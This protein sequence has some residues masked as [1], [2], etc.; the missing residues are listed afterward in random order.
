MDPNGFEYDRAVGTGFD[1]DFNDG[2]IPYTS[3]VGT[4]V[5]S[6]YQSYGLNDMVGNVN[7]WCWD[8]YGTPYGQPTTNN[9]TGA[10]TGTYRVVRGGSWNATANQLRCAYRGKQSP[11]VS[12]NTTGFR[13]VRRD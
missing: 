6:T 10:A 7:Q 9:P 3:P 13:C 8:W 12:T 11:T 4:F 1:P 2:V 5:P